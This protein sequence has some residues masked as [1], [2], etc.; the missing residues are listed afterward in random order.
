MEVGRWFPARGWQVLGEQTRGCGAVRSGGNLVEE[1]AAETRGVGEQSFLSLTGD[2]WAA[3]PD[4]RSPVR[5]REK[6]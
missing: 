1:R 6:F 3:T 2:A 5:E 4:G